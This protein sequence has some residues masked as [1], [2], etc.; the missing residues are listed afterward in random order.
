LV[1]IDESWKHKE[2]GP[3]EAYLDLNPSEFASVLDR[4]DPP[5]FN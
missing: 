2:V 1:R 3:S 4:S 5:M